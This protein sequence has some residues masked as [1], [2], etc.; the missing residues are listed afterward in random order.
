MEIVLILVHLKFDKFVAFIFV[1]PNSV[2]RVFSRYTNW[3]S[4]KAVNQLIT[5]N[6]LVQIQGKFFVTIKNESTKFI[7]NEL[8]DL[9][10]WEE[11][12]T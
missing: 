1:V 11:K 7:L 9:A 4:G 2:L 3:L 8:R 12:K 10:S 5:Q 6:S